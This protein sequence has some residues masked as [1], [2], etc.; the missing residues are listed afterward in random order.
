MAANWPEIAAVD[1]AIKVV[2]NLLLFIPFYGVVMANFAQ[3]ITI[4]PT[5]V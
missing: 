5:T 1:Y 2:V 4:K 3:R